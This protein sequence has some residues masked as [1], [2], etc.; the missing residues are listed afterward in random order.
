[1][2]QWFLCPQTQMPVVGGLSPQVLRITIPL[3]TPFICWSQWGR[4]PSRPPYL[5]GCVLPCNGPNLWKPHYP[6]PGCYRG[7]AMMQSTNPSV[8]HP[9][10]HAPH[11]LLFQTCQHL[12]KG[13]HR[14]LTL[15]LVPYS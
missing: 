13:D 5:S 8:R 10:G 15:G 12:H 9:L 6:S 14:A 3:L 4:D 11:P 1:M 2:E 7:R